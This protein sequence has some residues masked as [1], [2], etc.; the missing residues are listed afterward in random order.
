MPMTR[1]HA[2][3]GTSGHRESTASMG[4]YASTMRTYRV[5]HQQ[6][7]SIAISFDKKPGG[8]F[9]LSAKSALWVS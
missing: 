1:V 2:K 3:F 6:F 8:V 9:R 4:G 5:C 7:S